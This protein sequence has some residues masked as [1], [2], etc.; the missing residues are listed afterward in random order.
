MFQIIKDYLI[1]K[2][3]IKIITEQITP[4]FKSVMD[5][6]KIILSRQFKGDLTSRIYF[7]SDFED[8]CSWLADPQGHHLSKKHTKYISKKLKKL[9]GE[10]ENAEFYEA[11]KKE[12]L[13]TS[14]LKMYQSFFATIK[15]LSIRK[16]AESA[17]GIST[18]IFE[19]FTLNTFG[20]EAYC[21]FRVK[22]KE[23]PALW[24]IF[25]TRE[26]AEDWIIEVSNE[27][28]FQDSSFIWEQWTVSK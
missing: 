21:V 22:S 12:R 7:M 13:Y 25:S 15:Q 3:H 9:V 20:I 19:G 6:K 8:L 14:I 18:N 26:K 10:Y 2:K 4:D 24:K 27:P 28:I 1:R 5:A 17:D 11:E 23:E 16:D